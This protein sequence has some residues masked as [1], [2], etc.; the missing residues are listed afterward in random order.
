MHLLHT[1]TWT[2]GM[3]VFFVL[4]ILAAFISTVLQ[5][6]QSPGRVAAAADPSCRRDYIP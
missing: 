5:Q 1:M 6:R 4:V 2:A 3:A